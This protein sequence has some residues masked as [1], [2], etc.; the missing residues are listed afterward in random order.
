MI[1]RRFYVCGRVQGVGFRWFVLDSAQRHQLTGW[2]R[3]LVD[4]RVEV[5]AQG[6]APDVDALARELSTGPRAARVEALES[7]DE[8]I[9]SKLRDFTMRY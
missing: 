6:E 9:D 7:V 4:G 2:T 3:N 8:A 1:A 5:L